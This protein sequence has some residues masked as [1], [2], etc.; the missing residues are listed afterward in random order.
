MKRFL[1][2]LFVIFTLALPLFAVGQGE[3]KETVVNWYAHATTFNDTQNKIIAAFSDKN[4]NITVN[5]I[6]LP[7]N[8]TDKLQALLIALQSGDGSIDIFNADVTWTAIFASAGLAE[9]LDK[10]FP[11]SERNEFLPGTIEA[12]MYNGRIWGM[13]FRTDAG[14]FYYRKDLLEKY[15]EKVPTTWTELRDVAERIVTAER[16]AGNKMYGMAGSMKQYE[17]L[18]CNA[19]EW[20]FSYGGKVL[21]KKGNPVI[22]SEENIKA[23]SLIKGM[24]DK[25]LY[26]QGVLSY[27]SGD[28]RSL[29]FKGSLVFMRAW[30]KAWALSQN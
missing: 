27:G 15:G 7:E 10:E 26:P 30:P 17:G 1:M 9:P 25:G 12:N 13:P 6:E 21:D 22:D 29:M 14:V 11:I 3:A 20:F 18:T 4:P 23:L 28:V 24:I 19:V 5:L 8:T 2:V 16:A